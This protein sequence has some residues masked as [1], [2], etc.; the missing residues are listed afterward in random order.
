M[1]KSEGKAVPK[2]AALKGGWG[3]G[4][5]QLE[6]LFCG[7]NGFVA[8]GGVVESKARQRANNSLFSS[9]K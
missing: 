6:Q 1:S 3:Y 7:A 4:G 8:G 9:H 5:V 2:E